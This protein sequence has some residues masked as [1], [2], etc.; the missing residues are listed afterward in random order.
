MRL[1]GT[2]RRSPRGSDVLLT[3]LSHPVND[4]YQLPRRHD[5]YQL[6]RRHDNRRIVRMRE[7]GL[8][9]SR[10][11]EVGGSNPLW[12]TQAKTLL[13][14]MHQMLDMQLACRR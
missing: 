6:P 14:G 11:G 8:R 10:T 2:G 9:T 13:P 1:P 5:N 3:G 4:S 7:T 12:S